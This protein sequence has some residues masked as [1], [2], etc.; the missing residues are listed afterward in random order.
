MAIWDAWWKSGMAMADSESHD[1][2]VHEAMGPA[3]KPLEAGGA[4]GV[5]VTS[6][7]ALGVLPVLLG[8]LVDEHR[9]SA[10]YIGL[11]AM[12]ELLTM[13][14]VTGLAGMVLKPQRLR[15]IAVLATLALV[16]SDLAILWASGPS[17]LLLRASAGAAEGFLLWITVGMIA[18]TVTPERWAG[19][20]FTTQVLAQLVLAVILAAWVMSR[21]GANGGFAALAAASLIGIA[22]ALV[23]PSRFA[24]LPTAPGEGG[25]PPLRGWIALGA[26]LIY[27]SANGAVSVY[28][29][30]L[31]HQAGL[32]AG[33]ARTALWTSLVAQVAGAATATALAGRVRYFTVFMITTVVFLGVWFVFARQSPAWLFI[34]ANAF[35]GLVFLFLAPFLVPMIIDADPSRRAAMQ[36]GAAQ[37]LGAALGPLLASRVVGERDAHGVLWLAL[38]LMLVGF[39]MV[40]WLRFTASGARARLASAMREA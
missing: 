28:L 37:L 26:I 30:P 13:G 18:R 38:G 21:F 8:S 5:G 27:V 39:F 32:G 40:A 1:H 6:L 25:A 22:P 3:F 7:L 31:A 14:V 29:Q 36:S 9:M 10:P 19:V 24:P 11:A 34:A 20:F 4:I 35:G 16:A 2:L 15:L 17:I 33:V 23:S 12:L